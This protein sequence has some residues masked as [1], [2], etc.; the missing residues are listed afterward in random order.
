[1]TLL[2]LTLATLPTGIEPVTFRQR[3]GRSTIDLQKHKPG[4]EYLNV[5]SRL[6]LGIVPS[7]W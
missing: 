5:I 1:M 7:C 2:N 6:A 3:G 4:Q